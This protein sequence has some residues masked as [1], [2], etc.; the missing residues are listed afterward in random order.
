MSSVA[1]VSCADGLSSAWPV[2]SGGAG[3]VGQVEDQGDVVQRH[4]LPPFRPGG[5]AAGRQ[6]RE[7]GRGCLLEAV[8][9]PQVHLPDW[10][11]VGTPPVLR[12]FCASQLPGRHDGHTSAVTRRG[13]N[14]GRRYI[15]RRGGRGVSESL[16]Q[17]RPEGAGARELGRSVKSVGVG[18]TWYE[19]LT[20]SEPAFRPNAMEAVRELAGD[21][22]LYIAELPERAGCGMLTVFV[23][24]LDDRTGSIRA[25]GLQ[26]AARQTYGN[27]VRQVVYRDPG[28]QRNRLRRRSARVT[29]SSGR[30]AR[31]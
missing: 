31:P 14:S 23:D 13:G 15:S 5:Y 30:R 29:G 22:Y 24:D 12:H 26:P 17:R 21:R 8:S 28:R 9:C 1:S 2:A 4:D 6:Y 10:P 25:R 3:P 20:S 18:S 27:G 7:S 16:R 11:E 19:R